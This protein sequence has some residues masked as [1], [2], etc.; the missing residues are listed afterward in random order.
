M[1]ATVSYGG[2]AAEIGTSVKLARALWIVP[3]AFVIGWIKKKDEKTATAAKKPWFILGFIIAAALVTWIPAIQPMG[4]VVELLAKRTLILTL[5][6]I[7]LELSRSTFKKV[8]LRPFILGVSLWILTSVGS[9]LAIK[10]GFI[11]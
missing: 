10:T 5:F 4:K 9:L 6:F 2:I 11:E 8:G 1:G 7:G 3:V